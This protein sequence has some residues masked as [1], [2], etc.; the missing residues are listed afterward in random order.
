MVNQPAGTT[1]WRRLDPGAYLCEG[2]VSL[3]MIS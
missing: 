1:T 3:M 2:L